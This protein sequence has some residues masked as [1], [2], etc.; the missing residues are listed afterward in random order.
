M[1]TKERE[2]TLLVNGKPIPLNPFV[3]RIIINIVMGIVSSL[4]GTEEAKEVKL[5]IK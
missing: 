4:R 1:E 3:S 2:V 5:I